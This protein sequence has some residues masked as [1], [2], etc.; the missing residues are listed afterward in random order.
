M[1]GFV[2]NLLI[3]PVADRH[4]EPEAEASGRFR[5]EH[6][7]RRRRPP[8]KE[9]TMLSDSFRGI[10]LWIIVLAALLYGVV[11]TLTKVVD[12]FA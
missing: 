9:L 12:L 8:G 7:A 6:R 11:N 2:A 10:A 3:R 4:M 5:R 1:V